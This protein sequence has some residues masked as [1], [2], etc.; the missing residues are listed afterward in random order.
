MSKIKKPI[1]QI[2]KISVQTIT[3]K[4]ERK[5]KIQKI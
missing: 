1:E 2:K 4:Q 5:K 3:K